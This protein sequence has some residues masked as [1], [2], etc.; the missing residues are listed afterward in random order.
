MPR[1][2]SPKT[3]GTRS[4]A[5]V[6]AT[7]VNEGLSV[8]IPFGD[9]HRYDFVV[10]A[11]GRFVRVQVKTA[12]LNRGAVCFWSCSSA[13]HR[14]KGRRGY[15]GEA[16]VFA[17]YCPALDRVYFIPVAVIPERQVVLRVQPARNGQ[18]R[19]V[20]QATEYERWPAVLPR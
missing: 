16:D 11:T 9:N 4:E 15:R 8:S 19:N 5:M 2:A 20:R 1:P 6:L 7:L 17:V 12:V 10:E 3:V 13:T 14:G 18:L